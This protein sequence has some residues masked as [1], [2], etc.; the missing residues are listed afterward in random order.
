MQIHLTKK[1]SNLLGIQPEPIEPEHAEC[2]SMGVWYAN[3]FE[4]EYD[5]Y[6]THRENNLCLLMVNTESLM[7]CSMS[8]SEELSIEHFL[9]ELP[10]FMNSFFES[11]G[12]D[13]LQLSYLERISREIIF[14]KA[15]DRSMIGFM[16]AFAYDHASRIRDESSTEL[17]LDSCVSSWDINRVSR[18]ELAKQS[19]VD[20]AKIIVSQAMRR[21]I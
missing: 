4:V 12:F 11:Y 2:S 5:P 9:M 8:I 18:A 15:T 21:A 6:L 17:P 7:S 20:S 19:P 3:I 14:A 13:S 16:R 1:L 10:S